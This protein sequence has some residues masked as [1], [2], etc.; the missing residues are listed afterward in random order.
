MSNPEL[1]PRE[2]SLLGKIA[3]WLLKLWQQLHRAW[4]RFADSSQHAWWFPIVLAL[5]VA[6]DAFV[7][8]LPGDVVVSLAVLS[9]PKRWRR[10]A[11]ISAVGSTLGSFAL[12]L[13]IH[14]LGKKGLSDLTSSGLSF[15]RWQ[16]ARGFFRHYGL[17]SLALG[18]VLPGGTWPPV[19]MAGLSADRWGVV[20]GWLLL[21]RL[22]RFSLLSFGTREGWAIFQAVKQE[23]HEHRDLKQ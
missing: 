17:F 18:S 14:H 20:L 8:I 22:T 10:I 16:D 13:L 12:Y 2:R 21:G 5:L 15:P 19:V 3:H 11:V 23:A 7:V 1:S 9:N 4:G 6:F